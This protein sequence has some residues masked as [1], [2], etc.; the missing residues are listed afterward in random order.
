VKHLQLIYIRALGSPARKSPDLQECKRIEIGYT[1]AAA[2]AF[3]K[4][5]APPLKA[6]GKSFRFVY[7][8]GMFA[9]REPDKKL[10]FLQN[11][12]TIKVLFSD[13]FEIW[14]GC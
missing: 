6:R 14:N 13:I 4:F 3:A 1:L 10:L 7:L 2:E 5:L 9:N 12:R 11:S 8:S